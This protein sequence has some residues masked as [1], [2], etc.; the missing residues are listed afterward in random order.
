M[1]AIVVIQISKINTTLGHSLSNFFKFAFWLF[2]QFSP[3]RHIRQQ[4]LRPSWAILF[5]AVSMVDGQPVV[6]HMLGLIRMF[7]IQIGGLTVTFKSFYDQSKQKLGLS[8]NLS[9]RYVEKPVV[10]MTDFLTTS[11][12]DSGAFLFSFCSSLV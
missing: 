8:L 12:R 3:F 1:T 9:S 2:S 11:Y 10:F 4:A 5:T 7:L 6:L